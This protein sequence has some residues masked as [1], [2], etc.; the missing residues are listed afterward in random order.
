MTSKVEQLL[1]QANLRLQGKLDSCDLDDIKQAERGVS[2]GFRDC[3][4]V[5]VAH[6]NWKRVKYAGKTSY[7]FDLRLYSLD[8]T[9]KEKVKLA[10]VV[11]GGL[12]KPR[13]ISLPVR[14]LEAARQFKHYK[15]T[16]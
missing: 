5:F 3:G 11:I 6:L 14:N 1:E 7:N 4:K 12:G 13:A 8:D 2:C 10:R 15:E 16:S 9:K